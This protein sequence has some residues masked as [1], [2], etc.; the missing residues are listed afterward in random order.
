MRFAV[1]AR[2]E[3]E[4]LYCELE[5]K[6]FYPEA[7]IVRCKT[8]EET[9]N[10]L[11]NCVAD[12]ILSK[13]NLEFKS[14]SV[15]SLSFSSFEDYFYETYYRLEKTSVAPLLILSIVKSSKYFKNSTLTLPGRI[16]KFFE[17]SYTILKKSKIGSSPVNRDVIFNNTY[18]YFL[19]YKNLKKI[20]KIHH[21]FIKSVRFVGTGIGSLNYITLKGFNILKHADVCL[22]DSLIDERILNHLPEHAK[23][24][25]VGKRCKKHSAEQPTINEMLVHYAKKAL[26]VVRLKSGDPAIFGRLAEELE[27]LENRNISY[28]VVPGLSC[29]NTVSSRGIILT[30]RKTNRGFCVISPIKHGGDFKEIDWQERKKLPIALFM[31]VRVAEKVCK[32]LISEGWGKDTKTLMIF[33]LGNS[34]EKIISGNL[35]NIYKKIELYVNNRKQVPPGL[36]IIGNVAKFEQNKN[37]IFSNTRILIVGDKETNEN[38][39]IRLYDMGVS[40]EYLDFPYLNIKLPNRQTSMNQ[41]VAFVINERLVEKSFKLFS[42]ND[43]ILNESEQLILNNSS[44]NKLK[45]ILNDLGV[46]KIYY[47]FIRHDSTTINIL[48]SIRNIDVFKIKCTFKDRKK[49]FVNEDRNTLIF[50][51]SE[52]FWAYIELFGC[53]KLRAYKK[54]WIPKDNDILNCLITEKISNFYFLPDLSTNSDVWFILDNSKKTNKSLI[55]K[56]R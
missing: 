15:D 18:R 38:M 55:L 17:D 1:Y 41:N 24:I 43:G 5:I 29:I 20:W 23:I 22:H 3:I 2:D 6:K 10:L 52:F 45:D 12:A 35:S 54:I 4:A 26:R 7:Y 36:F 31:S 44:L 42:K 14:N 25:N 50:E 21:Y 19:Y 33:N 51:R 48:N 13:E 53:S 16:S 49:I 47:L 28:E 27:Y 8:K 56:R 46:G 32:N 39:S 37:K 34:R 11:E 40:V 9:T 30:K